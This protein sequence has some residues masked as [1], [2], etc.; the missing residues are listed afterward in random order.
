MEELPEAGDG[1]AFLEGRETKGRKPNGISMKKMQ[2][3]LE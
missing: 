1:P 2:E 3:K